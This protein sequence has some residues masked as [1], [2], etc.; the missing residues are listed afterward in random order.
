MHLFRIV[1]PGKVHL[2]WKCFLWH[3][4]GGHPQHLGCPLTPLEGCPQLHPVV[5][6][7]PGS[8]SHHTQISL[9]RTMGVGCREEVALSLLRKNPGTSTSPWGVVNPGQ[10]LRSV[11]S[12]K[13][14]AWLGWER[15]LCSSLRD[16]EKH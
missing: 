8:V 11:I 4:L 13:P 14:G 2:P 10:M 12:S 6:A 1:E 5:K 3:S 7:A 15:G 9:W 16:T